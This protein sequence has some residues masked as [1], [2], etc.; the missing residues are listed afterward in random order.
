M[1]WRN[2][3]VAAAAAAWNT[4]QSASTPKAP[5]TLHPLVCCSA[6]TATP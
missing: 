2:I 3:G 6:M 5:V 1:R 4:T